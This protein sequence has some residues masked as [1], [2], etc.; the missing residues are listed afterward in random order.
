MAGARGS[1]PKRERRS[2]P[3]GIERRTDGSFLAGCEHSTPTTE[4]AKRQG[5]PL[6]TRPTIDF[7]RVRD[8]NPIESVVATFVKLHHQFGN[9][10]GLCPFHHERTPSFTLYND[11]FHCFGC[12]A[13]GDVI[14]FLMAIKNIGYGEALSILDGGFV[15]LASH[16][17]T[18]QQVIV[19]DPAKIEAAQAIWH[20]A[21]P[22]A[23]TP[24]EKYLR[25]RGISLPLPVTVRYSPLPWGRKMHPALVGCVSGADGAVQAVH[26]IFLKED[27]TKAVLS[28]GNVKFSLG[29]VSGGAIRLGQPAT[30]IVVCAGI[31]D[32]LSLMQML[33][34]PV[35]ASTG[36]TNLPTIS[37]PEQIE[38]VVVAH[39]ADESG[40]RA[41]EKTANR[42]VF[43]GR[44][45]RLF[46][47]RDG[48]K[49][50]NEE[51]QGVHV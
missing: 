10:V 9:S 29:S 49:D 6:A 12:G 23:G 25:G 8:A 26:R 16:R 34:L 17:A 4:M 40:L 37:L 43:E 42:L 30:E 19:P 51:L 41:A 21:D 7:S 3:H 32:G 24:A 48:F 39:D 47:P 33:G 1:P 27:G 22:I 50:H 18:A 28:G 15:Q 5:K 45:V 14:D 38:S 35:W 46:P 31:E 11:H 36:D 20:S 13:H 2:T 44:R